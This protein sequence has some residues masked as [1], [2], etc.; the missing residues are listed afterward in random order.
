MLGAKHL[1]L[2]H[3]L[4][5]KNVLTQEEYTQ[6]KSAALKIKLP[7]KPVLKTSADNSSASVNLWWVFVYIYKF[8][9]FCV[10]FVIKLFLGI[11]NFFVI[12][13]AIDDLKRKK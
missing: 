12:N 4:L 7:Q 11:I 1:K 6:I 9:L 3:D 2:A 13:L 5:S 10:S 8:A